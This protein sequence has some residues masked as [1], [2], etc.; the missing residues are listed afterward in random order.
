MDRTAFSRALL[1]AVILVTACRA[2][3]TPSQTFDRLRERLG[4]TFD[5]LGDRL[6]WILDW[7]SRQTW[8]DWFGLVLMLGMALAVWA[9]L[10]AIADFFERQERKRKRERREHPTPTEHTLGF[11]FGRW[12]RSRFR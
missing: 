9:G 3:E 12:L 5:R 10:V 2:D 1:G 4:Q 6:D 8:S 11:R 7:I